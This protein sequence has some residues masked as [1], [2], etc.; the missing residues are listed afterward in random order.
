MWACMYVGM[1]VCMHA[2][3]VAFRFFGLGGLGGLG[4]GEDEGEGEGEGEGDVVGR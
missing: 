2:I 1:Y 3:C 4:E